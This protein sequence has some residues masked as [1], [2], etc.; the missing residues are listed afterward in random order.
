M[1]EKLEDTLIG[2]I[3]GMDYGD[4]SEYGRASK[5]WGFTNYPDRITVNL[6][7]PTGLNPEAT[8]ADILEMREALYNSGFTDGPYMVYTSKDWDLYLDNDY[9]RLGGNNASETLRDRIKRTAGI[10]DVRRLNRLSGPFQMIMVQMTSDVFQAV[11]G[12]DLT[13]IQWETMGGMQLH[14]KVL[15]IQ[16][17]LFYSDIDG[18]CGVCHGRVP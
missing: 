13:T 3:A 14:F 8:I 5:V 7:Q 1:A 4:S 6:T 9:A 11:N 17:P 15:C 16:T 10:I 12:L 2:E 18:N